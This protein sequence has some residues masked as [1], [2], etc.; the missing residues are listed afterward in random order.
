[1]GKKQKKRRALDEAS[2][3]A[4]FNGAFAGLAGLRDALPAAPEVPEVAA[5]APGPSDAAAPSA[6]SSLPALKRVILQ[7]EKKGRGGK[8]V[9][10]VRGFEQGAADWAQRLK[11]RLG[12]G[13]TVEDGDVILL[14]DVGD[15]AERFFVG[16]G[17]RVTRGN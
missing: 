16:E 4:P 12:C 9:T 5:T 6:S 8:T 14:G 11:K 15:A 2:P 17:V 7:R 1:M 3:N 10:R 13:A